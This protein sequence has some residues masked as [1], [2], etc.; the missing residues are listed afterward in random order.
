MQM[1]LLVPALYLF[2]R[3]ARGI[4]PVGILWVAA[5]FAAIPAE[6]LDRLGLPNLVEFGPFFLSGVVAYQLTKARSLHLPAWMWPITATAITALYLWRPTAPRGWMCSLLLGT[7]IPQF[8]E[9]SGAVV[10]KVFKVIAR[11]SYGIYLVH[12]ACDWLAFQVCAR[13]PV[14]VRLLILLA[15]VTSIP[16]V[17]HHTLEEPM[18]R[19]GAKLAA[20]LRMVEISTAQREAA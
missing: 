11:Y 1:Y 17:F 9:V 7:A 18:I 16:Y 4:V 10:V 5:F 2:V 3:M 12:F 8:K 13:L 14:W 19:V 6:H 15:T 20:K